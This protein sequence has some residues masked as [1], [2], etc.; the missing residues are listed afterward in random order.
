[1]QDERL[2]FASRLAYKCALYFQ[3]ETDIGTNDNLFVLRLILDF[4][5]G[6]SAFATSQG[7]TVRH[8]NSGS[9]QNHFVV[10]PIKKKSH[11]DICAIYIRAFALDHG[12]SFYTSIKMESL[13][14]GEKKK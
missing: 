8:G 3:I 14:G 12:C 2:R 6:I 7:K 10:Y 1:M 5:G 13:S 4:D 11:R 9:D